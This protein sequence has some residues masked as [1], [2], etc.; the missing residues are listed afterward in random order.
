MTLTLRLKQSN[1]QELEWEWSPEAP[2]G[3]GIQ[4]YSTTQR[5]CNLRQRAILQNCVNLFKLHNLLI[6]DFCAF[7]ISKT[8][9]EGKFL[10]VN[11]MGY[12]LGRKKAR[13]K[14]GYGQYRPH[15]SRKY[16]TAPLNPDQKPARQIKCKRFGCFLI[17]IPRQ[18]SAAVFLKFCS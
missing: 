12:F 6:W 2:T 1:Q 17:H 7:L 3:V 13:R 11:K 8:S 4:S 5:A 15:I 10:Q 9:M 18:R 14:Q 16:I